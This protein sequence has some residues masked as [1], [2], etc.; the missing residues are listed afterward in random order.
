MTAQADSYFP[1]PR[2]WREI[3]IYQIFTDRFADGDP[4][5]N[6]PASARHARPNDPRGVRGGDFQGLEA[7]L[8]YVH[9]LGPRAL[10]ITPVLLNEA[11]SAWHGYGAVDF[12]QISPQLGG[13]EALRSLIRSAHRRGIYVLIDVVLN[14]TGDVVTSD[15]PGWPRYRA[16]G[17]GYHLRWRDSKCIP[18]APFNNLQWYHNRGQVENWNDPVQ[19]VVGQFF[20][21]SDLRTELP[22]VRAALSE[23]YQRLIRETDCDGFR[24]DTVRHVE[25]SFWQGWCTS[26]RDYAA[27]LGK[28]NFLLFGE[29]AVREDARLAIY[30]GPQRRKER[31]FDSLLDFP[32]Y[33]A[34]QEVLARAKA[35]TRRL[36]ERWRQLT[37]PPYSREALTQLVTFIDN[38][39]QPR[40]LAREN[41]NGDEARLRQALVLL[42]A[43]PGIPCLY[44]GTEQGFRG[45]HD[46]DNREEMIGSGK[47]K[48]PF[49]HFDPDHSLYRFIA[50]LHD[51]R[52]NH[53]A[54]RSGR[55]T[56]IAD[57][58][59]GP[60]LYAFVRQQDRDVVL[61]IL[62]TSDQ[63]R[64]LS[65]A[66]LPRSAAK[67]LSCLL[68]DGS[69][70]RLGLGGRLPRLNVP[71]KAAWVYARTP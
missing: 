47:G 12:T 42:Y 17:E 43:S 36:T 54:L 64:K 14:H 44:Y 25:A 10:W 62:N 66:R 23:V 16:Q 50:R 27:T 69:P 5:N 11:S 6:P 29:V 18:P 52:A 22:E 7:N 2:D 3:S 33:F 1:S 9:Q 59:L 45:G 19:S 53:P 37:A 39:D 30:T 63:A 41:A 58:P 20:T 70:L 49:N 60:G 13:L 15:D 31:A 51:L 67:N 71:P 21:L 38:H 40:F 4:S 46:P 24:V 8:D 68:G 56:V 65:G 35:P 26:I 34:V 32:F 48:R 28:A 57:D 61:V 55:H